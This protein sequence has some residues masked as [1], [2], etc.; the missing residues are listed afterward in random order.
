MSKTY[1]SAPAKR[2]IK[3]QRCSIHTEEMY[4]VCRETPG[5]CRL[6]RESTSRVAEPGST[7]GRESTP[8]SSHIEGLRVNE[9]QVPFL[10]REA[11]ILK[12]SLLVLIPPE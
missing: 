5:A 3:T 8:R 6:P 2:A 9:A 12:Q 1:C 11:L 4:Q 7:G 10:L